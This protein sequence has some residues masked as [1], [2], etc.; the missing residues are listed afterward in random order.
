MN[1][2]TNTALRFSALS[3]LFI[4]RFPPPPQHL[5][6]PFFFPDRTAGCHARSCMSVDAYRSSSLAI[7][8]HGR[9]IPGRCPCS[10][11]AHGFGS[12]PK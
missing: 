6:P 11:Y 1:K 12:R 2:R 5:S 10:R 3:A 9:S 8:K 4:T 7:R